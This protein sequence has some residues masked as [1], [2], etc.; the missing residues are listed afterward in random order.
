MAFRGVDATTLVLALNND[1]Y[2]V[3]SALYA[4]IDA[5]ATTVDASWGSSSRACLTSTR[6]TGRRRR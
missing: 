6:P 3:N 5:P 2:D 1:A 4:A